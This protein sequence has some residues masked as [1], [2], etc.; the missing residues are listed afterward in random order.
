MR[1]IT[2]IIENQASRLQKILVRVQQNKQLDQILKNALEPALSRHVHFAKITK[3][4]LVVTVDGALWATRLIYATPEILK[5]LH[6][7][8]EFKN[9]KKIR[10]IATTT[11]E[12]VSKIRSPKKLSP[13]NEKLWREITKTL[14]RS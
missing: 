3:E 14:N 10:H 4:T 11:N 13:Q 8:E 12:V 2:N 9:I 1:T 7:Q 5:N 6:T